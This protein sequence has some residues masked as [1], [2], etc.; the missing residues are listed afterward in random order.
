MSREQPNAFW[1]GVDPGGTG[2]FGLAMLWTSGEVTTFCKSWADEAVDLVTS[3][4]LGVGVDA[5][6]WWS[7]GRSSERKA[8]QWIRSNYKIHPGTVQTANSLRG[9]ALV[10][11]V[12]FVSRLREK[13]PGVLVTEAHPKALAIALGGWNGPA[14]AK[15]GVIFPPREHERDATMAAIAAREGYEGRW[16]IDLSLVRDPSEQDPKSHWLGPVS[17]FWPRTEDRS[18]S[19]QQ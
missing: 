9:A 17:Y 15:L 13:F 19:N 14:I 7:S 8:D 4:P 18:V 1:V 5:P 6:L 3:R 16:T 10:Q 2:A 12:M 11:G